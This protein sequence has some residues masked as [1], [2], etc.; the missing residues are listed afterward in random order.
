MRR[1]W[2]GKA[3][4]RNLDTSIADA[5]QLGGR[6]RVERISTHGLRSESRRR[7]GL[8]SVR[9]RSTHWIDRRHRLRS[10]RRRAGRAR[11]AGR[12]TD[13]QSRPADQR[14][15]FAR[16]LRISAGAE[17]GAS[18]GAR[19]ATAAAAERRRQSGRT[20][21]EH[22]RP[23]AGRGRRQRAAYAAGAAAALSRRRQGAH[24]GR[25]RRRDRRRGPA[26]LVLVEPFLRVGRQ[27]RRARRSPAR[28]SA[29]RSAPMCSAGSATCCWRWSSIRR[30]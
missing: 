27:G 6:V 28:S 23:D 24:P 5:R 19:G 14:R 26:G 9:L 11:P 10:A 17:R 25:A 20:A 21:D 12:R 16:R 30:C 13:Q 3:D 29:R 22:P 15:R 7:A 4:G 8:A 2:S 18:G 1:P